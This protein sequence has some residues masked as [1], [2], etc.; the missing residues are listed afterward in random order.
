ME[1]KK[2][3]LLSFLK[4]YKFI[5]TEWKSKISKN[6]RFILVIQKKNIPTNEDLY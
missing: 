1:E 5:I 3:D 2:L 4:L 6:S